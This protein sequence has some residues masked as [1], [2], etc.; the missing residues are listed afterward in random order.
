MAK[1][2]KKRNNKAKEK[3]LELINNI[4]IVILLIVSLL[5]AVLI[6]TKSGSIGQGLSTILGGIMSI[7]QYLLPLGFF[8][9]AI[10][11]LLNKEDRIRGRVYQ[12]IALLI[13]L[14]VLFPAPTSIGIGLSNS[15]LIIKSTP[16]LSNSKNTL[17]LKYFSQFIILNNDDATRF[18]TSMPL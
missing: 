2:R 15:F 14:L 18:S 8:G 12:F 16:F 11:L 13:C 7:C 1:T 17:K 6:Y 9:I 3:D 4:Q 10:Y 5:L